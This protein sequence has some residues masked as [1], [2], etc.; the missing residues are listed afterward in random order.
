VVA[1]AGEGKKGAG[2]G[3][4]GRRVV[5]EVVTQGRVYV[6]AA[7]E[8][9]SARE[10]IDAIKAARAQ[11]ASN[12]PPVSHSLLSPTGGGGGPLTKS[13]RFARLRRKSF[14]QGNSDSSS[15]SSSDAS[16]SGS[17][18]AIPHSSGAFVSLQMSRC[19]AMRSS[20]SRIAHTHAQAGEQD[21]SIP[22]EQMLH[23]GGS[24]RDVLFSHHPLRECQQ[25]TLW[26]TNYR[27]I[28]TTE[29]RS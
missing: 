9:Q 2:G 8:E 1:G 18:F 16:T 3:A 17:T 23:G 11:I 29:V 15:S 12:P 21:K 25:A 26:A 19:D 20:H 28:F 7:H 6:L 24:E 10:W 27:L 13:S 22:G 5:F 4:G 14:N